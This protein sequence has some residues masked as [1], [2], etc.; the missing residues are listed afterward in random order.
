MSIDV[1]IGFVNQ[2]ANAWPILGTKYR[3]KKE[4]TS[5]IFLML[6]SLSIKTRQSPASSKIQ[7]YH[8]SFL[9]FHL[10]LTNNNVQADRSNNPNY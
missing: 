2:C 5:S 6:F 7:V 4:F 10:P 3:F 8:L 1:A 9:S